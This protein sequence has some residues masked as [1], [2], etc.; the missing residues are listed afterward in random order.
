MPLEHVSMWH[1]SLGWIRITAK[2][3]QNYYS[4][5][6]PSSDKT[7]ICDLC[8]K[9]VAF[10]T[11]GKFVS[12]F[13][14]NGGDPDKECADRTQA[15]ALSQHA[16]LSKTITNPIRIIIEANTID[17]QIGF[18]PLPISKLDEAEEL[19]IKVCLSSDNKLLLTKNINNSNFSSEETVFYSVGDAYS[20][21][22][23]LR[24]I[25]SDMAA[26]YP[27]FNREFLGLNSFG[28][29]FNYHSGKKM[30]LDGDIEV[31]EKYYLLTKS[32]IRPPRYISITKLISNNIYSIY[33]ISAEKITKETT[34]FFFKFRCRL[35]ASPTKLISLWPILHE[36]ESYIET[37][38]Q[39]IYFLLKGDSSLKLEPSYLNKSVKIYSI[40][41]NNRVQLI[42]IDNISRIRM[43]W[44]AR[45]SVLR[46]LLLYH[47]SSE[48]TLSTIDYGSEV[49]QTEDQ[50]FFS[51]GIY[52]AL[53]KKNRLYIVTKYDGKVIHK[54]NGLLY[55]S[56]KIRADQTVIIDKI[57]WGDDIKVYHGMDEVASLLFIRCDAWNISDIN[58]YKSL[59]SC[60]GRQIP[61]SSRNSWILTQVSDMPKTKA[62]IRDA[63]N[64]RY[65]NSNALN[66]IS[67]MVR[68]RYHNG[69]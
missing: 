61:F 10:M 53:P 38:K 51:S 63:L 56:E 2:D 50:Q 40:N 45:L 37:S 69:N 35:T 17:L 60:K 42:H 55:Y 49:I 43:L 47:S 27:L 1:E 34:D 33:V 16:S 20:D 54:R 23:T 31:G 36:S 12:H 19:K 3:A 64:K 48:R 68:E 25:P 66:M 5:Y 46:Y 26:S 65:I 59:L 52:S 57:T 4:S 24:V 62:F 29:L 13:K 21:K 67:K 39:H 30:P 14:H 44:A 7:F 6:V 28:T 18:L 9:H 32:Y 22:Y 15:F 8:H 58:F 41:T 11:G